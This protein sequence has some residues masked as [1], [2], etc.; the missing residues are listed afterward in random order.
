MIILKSKRFLTAVFILFLLFQLV[1]LVMI[2][3]QMINYRK[4][5]SK[6]HLSAEE[7]NG[8]QWLENSEFGNSKDWDLGLSGD[9]SDMEIDISSGQT[10][11]KVLGNE[12]KYNFYSDLTTDWNWNEAL[13]PNFPRLPDSTDLNSSGASAGHYWDEGP[14]Q[15]VAVNWNRTL[16]IGVDMSD[17]E[18]TSASLK[19]IVNGSVQATP[20]IDDDG[21]DEFTGAIDVMSDYDV[22]QN[23]TGGNFSGAT[24]DYVL[25]YVLVSDNENKNVFEIAHNQTTHLGQDDPLIENMYDTTLVCVPEETLIYY[26]TTVLSENYKN[27]TISVGMRI[28]CEDNFGQDADN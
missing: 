21:G 7:P 24:G 23:P 22:D 9:D 15:S 11:F 2:S 3:P 8:E 25:F 17:Y 18:I 13:N 14:D 19:A 20:S 28:W 12:S 1:F 10:N 6:I 16:N 27:F 4:K 5:V 26:L